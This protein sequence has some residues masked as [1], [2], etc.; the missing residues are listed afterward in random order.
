[1]KNITEFFYKWH[2]LLSLISAGDNNSFKYN[3]KI[4]NHKIVN[5]IETSTGLKKGDR[6]LFSFI[7]LLKNTKFIIHK[8]SSKPKLPFFA[9]GLKILA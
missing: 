1:M 3:D 8:K 4:E 2:E 7:K 6:E 5:S 9:L